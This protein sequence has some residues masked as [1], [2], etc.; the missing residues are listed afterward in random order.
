MLE[1]SQA[2]H[3]GNANCRGNEG[4]SVNRRQSNWVNLQGNWH[5]TAERV[6]S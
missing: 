3:S 5:Y 4:Y 1:K 2:L 6:K